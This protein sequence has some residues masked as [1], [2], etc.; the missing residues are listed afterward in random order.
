MPREAGGM[1]ALTNGSGGLAAALHL[2][3]HSGGWRSRSNHPPACLSHNAL[4]GGESLA[5]CDH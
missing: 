1:A 5:L 4:T 3:K 2:Q